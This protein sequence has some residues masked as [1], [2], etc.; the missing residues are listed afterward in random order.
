MVDPSS[1]SDDSDNDILTNNPKPGKGSK[2]RSLLGLDQDMEGSEKSAEPKDNDD[3]DS[4]FQHEDDSKKVDLNNVYDEQSGN[5]EYGND[6]LDKEMTFVP[7]MRSLEEKIRSALNERKTVGDGTPEDMTPWEKY[8]LK[9]KEKKREKKMKAKELKE[10]F[11]N[12]S[13]GLRVQREKDIPSST[14]A[15]PSSQAELNLLLAGD[16]GTLIYICIRIVYAL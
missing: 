6:D 1:S 14:S 5:D 16:E 10:S 2:L 9:R 15:E 4:F 11:K 8:Q 3:D 12:E 13:K 7:G